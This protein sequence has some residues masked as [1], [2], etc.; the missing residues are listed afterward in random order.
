MMD[1]ITKR[2]TRRLIKALESGEYRKMEGH[3]CNKK[4]DA[5]CCLGVYADLQG[6]TWQTTDN[7][8][9]YPLGNITTVGIEN[10]ATLEEK[11]A[12]G[13]SSDTQAEL[14]SINDSNTD[15]KRVI[16]YLREAI[17]PKA[18]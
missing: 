17:L 6:A 8:R 16:R 7:G 3:L 13:L 5:F 2:Q 1:T 4:G 15:F 14:A 10:T 11:W 9:L 18:K 12:G